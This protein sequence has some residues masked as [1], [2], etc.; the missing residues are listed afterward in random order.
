MKLNQLIPSSKSLSQK[1]DHWIPLSDLMT[2]LMLMFLL[3]AIVFMVQ[4]EADGKKLKALALEAERHAAQVREV[5]VLY[6]E[7]KS[8]L[9]KDLLDEFRFDLP[10]WE[11]KLEPDLTIRFLAPDVLF[12]TSDATIKP[13]FE[14]ILTEFFPRYAEILASRKFADSIEEIRIEGHTSSFWVGAKNADEAYF[15]NMALSQDRTKS[16]LQFVMLL[17]EVAHL[18]PWLT[19]R[20]TANGLSSSR[21]RLNLDGTE[22]VAASQ[23][24][25]FRVRTNAESQMGVLLKMAGQ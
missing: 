18:K 7:T 14:R 4:V 11:A 22:N 8:A 16:T 23:R 17:R 12:G 9:Y 15:K 10:R 20:L 6:D 13:K 2:G 1:E 19:S 5:A 21:L 3:V 24:V 25:E